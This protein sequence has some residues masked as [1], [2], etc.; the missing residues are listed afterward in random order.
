MN[1][2][3]CNTAPRSKAVLIVSFARRT[4]RY[5]VMRLTYQDFAY[6]YDKGRASIVTAV[7]CLVPLMPQQARANATAT[8]PDCH[9]CGAEQSSPAAVQKYGTYTGM[10]AVNY[11]EHV[12]SCI[13]SRTL[14]LADPVLP[15]AESNSQA[16]QD[17]QS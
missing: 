14:Y 10:D 12:G 1:R 17:V 7:A 2:Y 6:A 15:F 16:R 3:A 8:R 9:T 5:Q 13:A 11:D 4:K